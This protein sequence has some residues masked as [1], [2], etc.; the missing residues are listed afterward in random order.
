[1]RGR[2]MRDC[3]HCGAPFETQGGR[4]FCSSACILRHRSFAAEGD[5]WIWIGRKD[6]DGYGIF[7]GRGKKYGFRAHRESY[8]VFK[9]DPGS[10][11]VCHT[12][13]NPPCVNPDHLFLGAAKDNAADMVRKGRQSRGEQHSSAKFTAA[14]VL[15]VRAD[16]RGYAAIAREHGV[17]PR[18]IRL[19]K[20]G[21]TWKHV[22]PL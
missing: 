3:E 8:K 4:T 17:T 11:M 10:L 21:A 20:L 9:C 22:T 13:D 14:Q 2:W 12:C 7:G 19:M 6:K 16:S 5:C 15:S 18:T 1:M